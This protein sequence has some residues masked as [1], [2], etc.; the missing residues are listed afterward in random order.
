MRNFLDKKDVN[1]ILDGVFC[2]LIADKRERLINQGNINEILTTKNYNLLHFVKTMFSRVKCENF[3][4]KILVQ[5]LVVGT[6]HSFVLN[7][8]DLHRKLV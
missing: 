3:Y 7:Q 2:V 5:S 8:V 1:T 4:I 6:I